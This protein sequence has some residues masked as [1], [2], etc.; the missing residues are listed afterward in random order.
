SRVEPASA[1]PNTKV[2]SSVNITGVITRSKSCSG[3]CLNFSAARQPNTSALDR[4]EGRGGRATGR[5]RGVSV[6]SGVMH[7]LPV[8]VHP[9]AAGQREEHLLQAGIAQREAGRFQSGRQQRGQGVVR[10]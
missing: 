6:G 9:G 7:V 10:R 4:A 5:S 2:K 1:P 8:L 3:T